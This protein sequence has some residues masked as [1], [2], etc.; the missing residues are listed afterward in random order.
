MKKITSLLLILLLASSV[1]AGPEPAVS[2]TVYNQNLAL[3][4]EARDLTLRKGVQD[5]SYD[6]VA[7]RIDPTSVRFSADGA[8]VLEQNFEFD[9]VDRMSLMEKYLGETVDVTT[10]AEVIRGRLLSTSGGIILE[11]D[12]GN[13]R[14]IE[15]SVVHSVRFPELPQGLIIKPT[16]RWILDSKHTGKVESELYYL[17]G[18]IG[19][20]ASYVGVVQDEQNLE[21]SGWVQITNRSGA[22]YVDARL[23]LM[24]GDVQIVRDAMSRK[25]GR[26]MAVEMDTG[27]QQQEFFEYHLYTVSRLVTVHDNQTKQISLM[28]PVKVPSERVYVYDG[29]RNG[30]KVEVGINFV[31]EKKSGLGLPLPAGK[32]RLYQADD[33]DGS[34]QFVGEDR[35]DHTPEGEKVELTSGKA[36]DIVGERTRV[37]FKRLGGDRGR[38]ETWRVEVRNRK[39]TDVNVIVREHLGG[40]W[41]ILSESATSKKVDSTTVEWTLPVPAGGSAE[42]S[43]E[44]RI[45]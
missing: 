26:V 25:G 38:E 37:D 23:K 4:R 24:A 35:I 34:L 17:T 39:K 14:I 42:V 32:V 30:D 11:D 41:K 15:P 7:A 44:V 1:F 6:G 28:A 33:M 22:N 27:L 21:L 13:I 3:V 8:T 45:N 29:S 43:Y 5:F 16:L 40:D 31:N 18:G 36:F 10:E 20:E 12:D 2:L 19:W 9:L